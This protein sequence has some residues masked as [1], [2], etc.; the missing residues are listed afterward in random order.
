MRPHAQT[1][2]IGPD[3]LASEKLLKLLTDV[4]D[5]SKLEANVVQLWEREVTLRP[6]F[7]EW[8]ILTEGMIEKFGND[9]VVSTVI[10]ED[11][12]Q[13]VIVDDVRLTPFMNN[14]MDNAVRFTDRGTITISAV[15]GLSSNDDAPSYVLSIIDIGMGISQENLA[16]VF[17]RFRQV[18]GPIT[19]TEGGSGLGLA[20]CHDL[21]KLLGGEISV[22]SQRLPYDRMR[23]VV[24]H[25]YPA[26]ATNC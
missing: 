12:P 10:A 17:E 11:L 8:S 4:L 24:E 21:V 25:S 13:T 19:Q 14:L 9:I 7:N 2:W 22:L 5:I 18:D 16:V 26:K 15:V 20:I 3:E 1:A 6:I 23:R